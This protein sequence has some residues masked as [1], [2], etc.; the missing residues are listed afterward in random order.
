MRDKSLI[1]NDILMIGKIAIF[2]CV[3]LWLE[4]SM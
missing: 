3:I 1:L 4:Q 2:D